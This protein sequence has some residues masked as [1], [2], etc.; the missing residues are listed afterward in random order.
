MAILFRLDPR[1]HLVRT[2][3]TGAVTLTE[4]MGYARALAAQEL[5]AVPRLIDARRAVLA[6]SQAETRELAELMASLREGQ[7]PTGVAFV[8]GNAASYYIAENYAELGAGE[9]PG[10][11]IF[12]DVS[13]AEMWLT[14]SGSSG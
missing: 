12:D 8:A 6:V 14:L 3:F 9:N 4:L 5:V 10:Y 1:R 2:T 7:G 13:A 11:R